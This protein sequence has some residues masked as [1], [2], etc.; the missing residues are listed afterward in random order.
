MEGGCEEEFGIR[1][2][3]VGEEGSDLAV[4][5]DHGESICGGFDAAV[6]IQGDVD[7]L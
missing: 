5:P 3:V 1:L 6:L 7:S 4:W 2:E